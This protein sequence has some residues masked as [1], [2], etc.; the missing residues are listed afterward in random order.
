[1]W[2][3]IFF[4]PT[5]LSA[6]HSVAAHAPFVGRLLQARR[7]SNRLTI[8]PEKFRRT[9][10]IPM[11][12]RSSAKVFRISRFGAPL[13]GR[14]PPAQRTSAPQSHRR[15]RTSARPAHSVCLRRAR[16]TPEKLFRPKRHLS[17]F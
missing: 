12:L 13:F 14:P 6:K 17:L 10:S 7:M 4:R 16:F 11:A 8:P 9:L 15:D 2:A 1:S 5:T 3:S